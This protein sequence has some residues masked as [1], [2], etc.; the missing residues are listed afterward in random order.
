MGTQAT[1]HA[2]TFIALAVASVA[3]T[4]CS[5]PPTAP[6]A[7]SSPAAAAASAAADPANA[8]QASAAD[9]IK[10]T[11]GTLVVVPRVSGN[12]SLR[13]SHG[14]RFDGHVISGLEPTENC[15]VF[16]PCQPGATVPFRI[17]WDGTDIPGTVRLEGEEFPAG[18]LIT[19][20]L[21]IELAGSF[22]APAHVA[23]TGTATVPFT[24]TGL[25]SRGDG[26]PSLRLTGRGH[27]TFTLTWQ[28]LM[29]GWGVSNV[30]F[31]F[32]HGGGPS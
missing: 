8:V 32:G 14:F 20:S 3:L 9:T 24:A 29:D 4:A 27:V 13:G 1:R 23:E 17:E 5:S 19:A 16:N 7:R 18:S 11:Q 10:I 22:V 12:V 15:S 31:D 21:S 26:S 6:S 28:P 25:L 2:P 30:S